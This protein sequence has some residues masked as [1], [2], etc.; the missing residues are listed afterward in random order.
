MKKVYQQEEVHS[1]RLPK[2]SGHSIQSP[3]AGTDETV[4]LLVHLCREHETIPSVLGAGVFSFTSAT[5]HSISG[6]FDELSALPEIIS[7]FNQITDIMS[8]Q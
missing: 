4:F 1:V 5:H 3:E 7:C 8:N 6:H 2:C